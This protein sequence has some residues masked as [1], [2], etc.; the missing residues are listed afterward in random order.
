MPTSNDRR[1]FARTLQD[2]RHTRAL[3]TLVSSKKISRD[4]LNEI[5]QTV[6][7]N[8]DVL[9]AGN[10]TLDR[11]HDSLFELVRHQI[12]LP[13]VYGSEFKWDI[14]HPSLLLA[15]SLEESR[16]MREL[17]VDRLASHPGR[18]TIALLFDELT[19]G[20]IAHPQHERKTMNVAYTF[21][22]L[23]AAACSSGFNWQLPCVLRS[24]KIKEIVGGWSRCLRDFVR[25]LHYGDLNM[26][27][28]GVSFMHGGRSYTILAAVGCICA[29]GEGLQIAFNTLGANAI[30]PCS[31]NCKNVLRK[32]SSLAHRRHGFV[33]ITC[34]DHRQL[35]PMTSADVYAEVDVVLRA[36]EQHRA[37][38]LTEQRL[39]DVETTSGVHA[40]PEG[41][42]A[43][44]DLRRDVPIP[45][46]L[47]EDWMHGALQDGCL[48]VAMR[49]YLQDLET[50]DSEVLVKL[51]RFLKADWNFLST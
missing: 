20:S 31:L 11:A 6:R 34:A 49:C 45:D 27:E 41:F 24:A 50:L 4:T 37:G 28:F 26:P 5:L 17:Y 10:R 42:L 40:N 44:P 2:G 15:K 23:G 9:L 3:Q 1:K 46:V 30:R 48:N 7:D 32:G 47:N 36:L 35:I 13:T 21:L 29:D 19:P 25:L 33:E 51:E 22:E 16:D 18:W 14:A 8:P 39:K 43:D 38:H 12:V